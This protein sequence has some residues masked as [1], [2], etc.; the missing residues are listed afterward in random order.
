MFLMN[1]PQMVD[2]VFH[3]VVHVLHGPAR[4]TCIAN[5]WNLYGI[6]I[7]AVIWPVSS[8][9]IRAWLT[10]S[11]LALI[12]CRPIWIREADGIWARLLTSFLL[13]EVEQLVD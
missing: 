13:D 5:M 3:T 9:F 2:I 1:D 10:D 11:L 12:H 4:L 8:G 7:S 6:Q